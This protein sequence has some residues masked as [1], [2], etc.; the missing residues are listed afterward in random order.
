[1]GHWKSLNQFSTSDL[2]DIFQ[3]PQSPQVGNESREASLVGKALP[4]VSISDVGP[5]TRTF[6]LN[7]LPLSLPSS[8]WVRF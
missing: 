6:S 8:F 1:M 7:G 2:S 3:P 4:Q 5:W